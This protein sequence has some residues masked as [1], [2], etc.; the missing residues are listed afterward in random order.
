MIPSWTLALYILAALWRGVSMLRLADLKIPSHTIRGQPVRLECHYDLEG[1]ALYSVKWYKDQHEFFR[2]IVADNPPAQV[3][4]LTGVNVDLPNSS[5]NT[6]TL[7]SVDLTGSGVY[8]CEVSGEAPTF[9]TVGES[10]Q[11]IVVDLPDSGGPQIE[12]TRPRYGIGD[13]VRINCT[14]SRSR[15]AA[16]LAW[17]INA[18]PAE[19]ALLR[20]FPVIID[21]DGLE[22]SI[23][24]LEFKVRHKHFKKGDLKMK[25]LATIANLYWRSNEESV[26]GDRPQKAPVLESRETFSPGKREASSS[27]GRTG[28]HPSNPTTLASLHHLTVTITTLCSLIVSSAFASDLR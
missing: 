2:F 25:C 8:R 1:E 11:M 9:Q 22:T 24:G 28:Q 10:A 26:E 16:K 14:S 5:D 27:V 21:D 15:P 4:N 3:V 7:K 19:E 23:L 13:T 12:G 17:F 18:D 20:H 6:V